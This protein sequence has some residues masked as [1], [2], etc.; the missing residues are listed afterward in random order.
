MR[1]GPQVQG[2]SKAAEKLQQDSGQHL[3]Y[4]PAVWMTDTSPGQQAQA[5][6]C[7]T[8]CCWANRCI[9][10]S[11]SGR[12]CRIRPWEGVGAPC[13]PGSKNPQGPGFSAARTSATDRAGQ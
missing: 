6:A 13:E 5:A 1:N 9:R 4:C 2:E 3:L 10:S 12:K 7:L 8:W 11:S